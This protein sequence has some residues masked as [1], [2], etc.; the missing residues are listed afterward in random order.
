MATKT[1]ATFQPEVSCD[2]CERT[3]LRGETPDVFIGAGRRHTVC[4][5]CAPRAAHEGWRREGEVPD[6]ELP[7]ARPR[8]GTA[9]LRRLRGRRPPAEPVAA[10]PVA[11]EPATVPFDRDETG[12]PAAEAPA[13]AFEQI[14]EPIA[15]ASAATPL[16]E[17]AAVFN[18]SE[19][20]RRIAGVARSLGAPEVSI[21]SAEHHAEVVRILIAWELSW[22]R[23]EVDLT[24][25]QPTARVLEQGSEL[26][27][28]PRAERL[29]N[30]LVDPHGQ[31][32]QASS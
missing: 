17:A 28:L 27:E 3:L 30:A 19:F 10:E 32:V 9:L 31:I 13:D 12:A 22:Y 18:E 11:A 1:I 16:T 26:T 7:P 29:A 25:P 8:H 14:V 20:P 6:L 2:I 21:W 4:E 23:Y 15:L 5:L 24:E